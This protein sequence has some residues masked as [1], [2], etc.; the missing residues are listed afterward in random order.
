MPYWQSCLHGRP[1]ALTPPPLRRRPQGVYACE[2]NQTQNT[3]LKA[4]GGYKYAVRSDYGATHSTV[5]S[6]LHGLD[7]EFPGAHI[8]VVASA[9][10]TAAAAARVH[11]AW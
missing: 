3:E 1:Q 8:N 6:A 7:Q 10:V 11:L 2:N 4:W 9:V 5:P